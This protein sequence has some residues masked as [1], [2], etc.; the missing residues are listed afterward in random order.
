M[1]IISFHFG[2]SGRRE[3]GIGRITQR[4]HIDRLITPALVEECITVQ[5]GN[6]GRSILLE[7]DDRA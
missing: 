4:S 2:E 5:D 6:I 7:F 3:S 1:D